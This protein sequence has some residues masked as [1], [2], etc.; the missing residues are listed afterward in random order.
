[1]QL[2]NSS[3]RDISAGRSRTLQLPWDRLQGQQDRSQ[4]AN[5]A[6]SLRQASWR[7]SL[8]QAARDVASADV[9][10]VAPEKLRHV[11]AETNAAAP[12][13]HPKEAA[14]CAAG[15]STGAFEAC[16]KKGASCAV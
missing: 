3:P 1:M 5:D 9:P 6:A 7:S 14:S 8:A 4:Q 2:S 13:A 11:Q 16:L 15:A 12:V 10:G